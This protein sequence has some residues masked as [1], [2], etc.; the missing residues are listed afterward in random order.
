MPKIIL[1]SATFDPCVLAPFRKR[2]DFHGAVISDLDSKVVQRYKRTLHFPDG[3]KKDPATM[4][5]GATVDCQVFLPPSTRPILSVPSLSCSATPFH[6][7]LLR[8]HP[9]PILSVVLR[10][11]TVPSFGA[12]YIFVGCDFEA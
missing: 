8:P 12:E 6:P 7:Y 2:T 10:L 3:R 9:Y 5:H 4:A 11:S 1:S